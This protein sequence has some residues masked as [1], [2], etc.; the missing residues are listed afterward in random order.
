M[1]QGLEEKLDKEYNLSEKKDLVQENREDSLIK[2]LEKYTQDVVDLIKSGKL[3][4][5]YSENEYDY[6]NY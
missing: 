2:V 3:N 1:I 6:S 5:Y 4:P